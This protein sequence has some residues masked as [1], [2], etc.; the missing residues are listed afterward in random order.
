MHGSFHSGRSIEEGIT[1]TITTSMIRR[2]FKRENLDGFIS[3]SLSPHEGPRGGVID[4][5]PTTT[6]P[7]CCIVHG[8]PATFHRDANTRQSTM[9][10][11]VYTKY[12]VDVSTLHSTYLFEARPNVFKR[13]PCRRP[14]WMGGHKPL[15][16]SDRA[17][18]FQTEILSYTSR[19]PRP[20]PHH[21]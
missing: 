10:L 3:R 16:N 9:M 12:C 1:S 17:P 6:S 11:V 4:D 8:D 13:F 14:L 21:S 2:G 18:G 5:R 19:M 20:L 15:S 7:L